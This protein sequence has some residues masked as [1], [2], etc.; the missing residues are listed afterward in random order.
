LPPGPSSRLEAQPWYDLGYSE[1][2]PKPV[3][4]PDQLIRLVERLLLVAPPELTPQQPAAPRPALAKARVLL[5]EDNPINQT[6]ALRLL[7]R[8]GLQADLASDGQQ[9]VTLA[10]TR[11]YQLILMDC[12]MPLLDGF[13]ATAALRTAGNQTPIVAL[14]ANALPGDRE[15][16]LASGMNDYLTKPLHRG[17]LERALATWIP[18]VATL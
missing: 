15:R 2:L 18:A 11:E 8:L 7:E 6:L 16:C 1:I 5:A 3:S 17:E 13:A 12:Q 10:S 9:A 4:R 14:T